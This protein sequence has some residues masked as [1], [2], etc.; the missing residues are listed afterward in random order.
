MKTLNPPHFCPVC[1]SEMDFDH[2]NGAWL[3]YTCGYGFDDGEVRRQA[4][5]ENRDRESEGDE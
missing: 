1:D 2:D 4:D 3:C 5:N